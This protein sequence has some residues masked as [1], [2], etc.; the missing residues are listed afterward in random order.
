MPMCKLCDN[1]PMQICPKPHQHFVVSNLARIETEDLWTKIC[2]KL[3][4]GNWWSNWNYIS[5]NEPAVSW[6][7]TASAFDCQNCICSC[8]LSILCSSI[9]LEVISQPANLISQIPWCSDF[10]NN[11]LYSLNLKLHMQLTDEHCLLMP[12]CN[13]LSPVNP[14]ILNL[15]YSH[16]HDPLWF[17]RSCITLSLPKNCICSCFMSIGCSPGHPVDI[18]RYMRRISHIPCILN[19]M[20]HF[21]V[22]AASPQWC[23]PRLHMHLTHG[24]CLLPQLPW[25]NVSSSKPLLLLSWTQCP[26]YPMYPESCDPLWCCQSFTAW[27]YPQLHPQMYAKHCVLPWT[28]RDNIPSHMNPV[29]HNSCIPKPVTCFDVAKAPASPM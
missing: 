19:P 4:K 9:Y 11:F 12:R 7:D 26:M 8:M 2:S 22:P 17:C 14:I 10:T 3:P 5:K 6:S 25:G 23:Y 16:S 29:T 13:I 15:M 21:D 1:L 27:C 24:H 28:P 18:S 20:T